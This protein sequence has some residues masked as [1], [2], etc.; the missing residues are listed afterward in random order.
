MSE[1]EWTDETWNPVTGCNKVSPGCAHCYAEGIAK[2]F[3][4]DREFSD[5]QFHPERL[6]QP[7]RWRKPRMVFVNSM[8]DLFHESVTDEQLDQI[9]AVMA[10]TPQHTYQVLTK[11]PERMLR[12]MDWCGRR[13][14]LEGKPVSLC[15]VDV[16]ENATSHWSHCWEIE[17]WPLPNVWLGVTVEN[18]RT[19]NERIPLLLQTPAAVRFLS[20]EPLLEEVILRRV[21]IAAI[22]E[23]GPATIDPLTGSMVDALKEVGYTDK[24][25]WIIAG[26]ESG[27]KSRPCDIAWIRSIVEQCRD[28]GTKCFV[29]QMGSNA[30]AR[31]NGQCDLGGGNFNVCDHAYSLKESGLGRFDNCL[32]ITSKGNNPEEWPVDLRVREFPEVEG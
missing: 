21:K 10:L 8:S 23:D 25:D 7:L 16:V 29:K 32:T 30:W 24:I 3:W 20:C 27:P 2:R 14:D 28:A 19:A 4:G 6:E 5:V 1:I 31:C 18:Q 17:R 13:H 11:R 22:S 9:F 26:G 15:R 12:Y